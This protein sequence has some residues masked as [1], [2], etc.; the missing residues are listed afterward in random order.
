M[1]QLPYPQAVEVCR[2]ALAAMP[3]TKRP[4]YVGRV[5]EFIPHEWV[6]HAIQLAYAM[7]QADERT[8]ARVAAE[9][10]T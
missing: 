9:P 1:S 7:G 2:A 3:V 10:G 5:S 8:R 4:Q 6:E